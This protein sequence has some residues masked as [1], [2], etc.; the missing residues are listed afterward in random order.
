MEDTL[1]MKRETLQVPG[2]SLY[3][4]VRGSG[5]V[6]LLMPGGPA[7]ATTF[8]KIENRLAT[9]YTAVTYDPRGLS[10]STLQEPTDDARMIQIFADDVHRLLA[11]LGQDRAS[12]FASSGGAVIALELIARHPEQLD[13]VLVHEPPSPDLMSDPDKVRAA[14]GNVCDTHA[15]EGMGPA[16]Q[17]FMNMVGIVGGPPP[18]SQGE[19]SPEALEAMAMM[20]KNME[21]F[22]GRYI[23]N[24][25]RSSPDFEALKASPCRIV[26]A[27]GADSAG[28]LA[29]N[30]GLGLASILGTEATV[31]PGDHSGYDGHPAE[32]AEKLFQVLEGSDAPGERGGGVRPH[33]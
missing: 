9:R 16:A 18:P 25:A 24:L 30:G 32:F 33:L 12:I 13:V 20:Q 1:T 29:H 27:V 26:P 8:R 5:P 15:A 31:F 7:D 4:E 19:P 17:R 22:F 14:M 11:A 6:L 2:A 28:Q 21:Y 23:R 10:H 3:Y